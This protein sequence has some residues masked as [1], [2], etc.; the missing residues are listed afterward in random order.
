MKCPDCE[1]GWVEVYIYHRQSFTRDV[2]SIETKKE[3]TCETCGGS[4]EIE[5]D[6]DNT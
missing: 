2:G 6:D 3:R 1:D 4:G 5:D